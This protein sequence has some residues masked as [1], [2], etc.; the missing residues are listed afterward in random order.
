M[1][2]NLSWVTHEPREHLNSELLH[3]LF[4]G[5]NAQLLNEISSNAKYPVLAADTEPSNRI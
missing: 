2:H 1:S 4:V 3:V 5:G